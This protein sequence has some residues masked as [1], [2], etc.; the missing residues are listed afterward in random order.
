MCRDYNSLPLK[1]NLYETPKHSQG[2]HIHS[3]IF[4]VKSRD[5]TSWLLI[6]LVIA[7]FPVYS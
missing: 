3:D 4:E 6:A 5:L 1:L 2:V 7:I